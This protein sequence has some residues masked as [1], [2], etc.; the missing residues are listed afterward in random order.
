MRIACSNN[1]QRVFCAV[2]LERKTNKPSFLS[3]RISYFCNARRTAFVVTARI[4]E[5]KTKAAFDDHGHT[6]W[7]QAKK[8]DS[9]GF[10]LH[11]KCPFRSFQQN[12]VYYGNP[13]D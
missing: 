2:V 1:H 10:S 13:V 9:E 6:E 12:Y 5:R 7:M 3:T 8:E 4:V 11:R